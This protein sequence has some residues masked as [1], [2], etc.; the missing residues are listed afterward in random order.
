MENEVVIDIT[1]TGNGYKISSPISD[2]IVGSGYTIDEAKDIA[3]SVI[4]NF[5]PLLGDE[6]IPI[7]LK[8]S[9]T[10]KYVIHK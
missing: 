4:K 5:L 7:E 3:Q 6:E 9:Y 8:K 2:K 1:E 10:L